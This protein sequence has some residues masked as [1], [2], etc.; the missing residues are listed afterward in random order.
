MNVFDEWKKNAVIKD[1][2]GNPIPVGT[3]V[4]LTMFYEGSI[5]VIYHEWIGT[6][7]DEKTFISDDGYTQS[8]E[9]GWNYDIFDFEVIKE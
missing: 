7:K 3:R 9:N 2:D 1:M 8:A 6:V 4:K 5:D